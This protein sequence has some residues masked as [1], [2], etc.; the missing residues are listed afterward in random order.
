MAD[1]RDGGTTGGIWRPLTV[2]VFPEETCFKVSLEHLEG[3][4][5][6]MCDEQDK[7]EAANSLKLLVP[8]WTT[9]EFIP[10]LIITMQQRP[11]SMRI[12]P[13]ELKNAWT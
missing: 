9:T 7:D 13:I 1:T 5:Q 2:K 4:G 3:S 11:L 8:L 10:V 6:S 12:E